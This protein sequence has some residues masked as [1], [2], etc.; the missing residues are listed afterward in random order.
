MDSKR[1]T[2]VW[3]FV[4]LGILA[5]AAVVIPLFVVPMVQL[6]TVTIADI[7]AARKLWEQKGPRD[8]DM[9]LRKRG[10]VTGTFEVQVRSGQV[11]AVTMDGQPLPA[12]QYADYSMPAVIDDLER[13]V[14]LAASP[15]AGPVL[16]RARFDPQDGHLIRYVRKD[17]QSGT[18]EVSVKLRRL[19]AAS[20]NP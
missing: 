19:D 7:A 2:W 3:F 16:L 10:S 17:D 11:V 9:T 13:F 18:L 8:Y 1:R 4:V 15:S 6:K 12:R 14:E 20:H 5:V